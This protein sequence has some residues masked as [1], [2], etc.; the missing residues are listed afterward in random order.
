MMTN[1]DESK[2]V[3]FIGS[4]PPP[5]GGATVK[6]TILIEA[7]ESKGFNLKI[8]NILMS[9]LSLLKRLFKLFFI[10]DGNLIMSLSTKGRLFFIPYVFFLIKINHYRVILLPIG[11]KIRD[12]INDMPVP[13]KRLYIKFLSEYDKIYVESEELKHQ[14]ENLINKEIVSYLPNFKKK[15]D[16][17]P[18]KYIPESENFK[19]VYLG[20]MTKDKGIFDMV[21]ALELIGDEYKDIEMH[22]YGSF[23]KN[24]ALKKNFNNK[25]KCEDRIKYHGFLSNKKLIETLSSYHVFIFPTYHDGECFPGVLLDAFFAGLPVIA[26]DWRFNSEII[27]TGKN[28]LLCNPRDPEDLTEK[29]KMLYKDENLLKKMSKNAYEMSKKY[30]VEN[31]INVLLDD[32]EELGWFR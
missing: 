3:T 29:I 5:L 20:M 24:D 21:E 15:P 26:T 1:I 2:K 10:K 13:L 12:E 25:I 14:L 22:F 23:G 4:L 19:V 16:D 9:K 11:G 31:V 32:L 7:L 30:D 8:I 28:G 27:K 18:I 17:I 6:N